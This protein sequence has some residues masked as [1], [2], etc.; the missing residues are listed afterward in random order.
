[1]MRR[2]SIEPIVNRLTWRLPHPHRHQWRARWPLGKASKPLPDLILLD[3][4]MPD[5]DGYD[6]CRQLMDDPLTASIPVIFLTIRNEEQDEQLGF[7]AGART[8]SPSFSIS[9]RL[10]SRASAT[11]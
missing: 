11:T 3:I 8:T 10:S 6:V 9:P 4:S 2:E 1:M 5:R 7:D